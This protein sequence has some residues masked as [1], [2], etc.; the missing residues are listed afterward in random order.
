MLSSALGVKLLLEQNKMF[1]KELAVAKVMNL[2]YEVKDM[3]AW[4]YSMI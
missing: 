3:P 4:L 2:R 1:T